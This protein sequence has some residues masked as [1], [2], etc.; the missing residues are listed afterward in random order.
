MSGICPVIGQKASNKALFS[1]PFIGDVGKRGI[2]NEDWGLLRFNLIRP[3]LAMDSFRAMPELD[4]S[5][6]EV[7]ILAFSGGQPAIGSVAK[8]LVR[9]LTERQL[10]ETRLAQSAPTPT[11]RIAEAAPPMVPTVEPPAPAPAPTPSPAAS[12][13]AT[14]SATATATVKITP[15][16]EFT[17]SV[18]YRI[19]LPQ[20]ATKIR[21]S[22]TQEAGEPNWQEVTMTSSHIR[23]PIETGTWHF[24]C[25]AMGPN[26]PVG[27]AIHEIIRHQG[28]EH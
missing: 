27:E 16:P 15:L 7:W 23:L 12:A 6:K 9:Q 22:L 24:W 4:L 3:V 8:D 28:G 19:E 18:H 11:S 13:T 17:N 14:S 5:A 2:Y 10:A 20:G 25:Q 1:L 21:Y 26:G